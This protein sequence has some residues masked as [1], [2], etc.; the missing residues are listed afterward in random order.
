MKTPAQ[1]LREKYAWLLDGKQQALPVIVEEYLGVS[2]E[3]RKQSLRSWLSHCESPI[4][5]LLGI[6]L[7]NL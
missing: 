2:V 5:Q 7:F 6:E 1:R 3:L 4:E